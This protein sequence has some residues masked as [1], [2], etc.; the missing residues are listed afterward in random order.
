MV[1]TNGANGAHGA[2]GADAGSDA[3]PHRLR[4]DYINYAHSGRLGAGYFG[5]GSAPDFTGLAAIMKPGPWP[6]ILGVGEA[7]Q[8]NYDGCAAGFAAAAALREA[9]GPPYIPLPGSLPREGGPFGPALL[10]DPTTVQIQFWGGEMERPGSSARTRNLLRATLPGHPQPF[11]VLIGHGDIHDGDARLA[12]FKTYARLA[13]PAIPCI[14]IGDCNCTPSGPMWE[15]G[16][17]ND[18]L[19]L[20]RPERMLHKILWRHGPAQEGPYTADTRALD[21]LCG[22]WR[23]ARRDWRRAW[24]RTIP[25]RRIGGV[26]FYDVAEQMGVATPTQMPI[27]S[28]RAPR[29]ID[30]ALVNRPWL[31]AITDFRVYPPLQPEHPT[32]HLR[33]SV[34]LAW[35]PNAS[36][37]ARQ[38]SPP[39]SRRWLPFR[40]RPHHSLD[41][42][43]QPPKEGGTRLIR[44]RP[45]LRLFAVIGNPLRH[46]HRAHH[47]NRHGEAP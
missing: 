38:A 3:P 25:G 33:I 20:Q 13:D 37:E 27:A 1:T 41:R 31:E 46:P 6:D 42:A 22:W 7:D 9:G 30:R 47:H 11:H 39:V 26:G 36:A 2:D 17:F 28:G 19:H 12:D 29:A 15:T 23:P 43:R 44:N 24:L 45:G 18:P 4:V 5:G 34:G 35:S 40:G 21:V 8:W 16:E 32:D 10:V 14:F